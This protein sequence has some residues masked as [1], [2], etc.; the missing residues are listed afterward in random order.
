MKRNYS[1]PNVPPSVRECYRMMRLNQDLETVKRLHYVYD[2]PSGLELGVWEALESLSN[3]VDLSDPDMNLPNIVHMLQTAEGIRAAGEPDWMQL[4]GLI[5]DLGKCIYLRGNDADGTSLKQQ[6]A[7][8]GDTFV[9]GEP[10]PD[11]LVHVE[12]NSLNKDHLTCIYPR[13]CG[14]DKLYIS[15]GHDEYLYQIMC[16]HRHSLPLQALYMIRYHSL[17]AWHRDGHYRDLEDQCDR[18]MKP[19]VQRFNKYD[20]YTKVNVEYSADQ[21]GELK[22]YYLGLISKYLGSEPLRL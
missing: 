15:Y 16:R 14:M 8:V 21:L 17:Y 2:K 11:N 4:V 6:W 10:L 19:W 20:L 13:E 12:F 9:V 5:H 3:F 1:A 22:E 7:I 18:D